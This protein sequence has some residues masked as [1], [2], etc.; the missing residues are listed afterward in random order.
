M[1]THTGVQLQEHGYGYIDRRAVTVDH[2]ANTG[3]LEGYKGRVK[4][5]GRVRVQGGGL[6][7]RTKTFAVIKC[8]QCNDQSQA[9]NAS[10][11]LKNFR[12]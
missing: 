9:R 1:C 4:C 12:T 5:I 2:D 10:A 11:F 8:M 7:G 6:E 3:F